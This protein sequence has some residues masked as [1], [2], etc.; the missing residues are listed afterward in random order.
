MSRRLPTEEL[1]KATHKQLENTASQRNKGG[2]PKGSPNKVTADARAAF[3][4][5]LEG[6]AN[7]V[8]KW[9]DDVAKKDPAKACDLLLRLAE[10]HIPKLARTELANADTGELVVR[11]KRE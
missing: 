10:F 8:G 11:V 7:K 9:I 2:R 3:T 6:R 5:I 1:I 4:K